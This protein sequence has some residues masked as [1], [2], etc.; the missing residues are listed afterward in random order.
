[1]FEQNRNALSK[2]AS[3]A[4]DIYG[5]ASDRL[6]G[7]KEVGASMLSGAVAQPVAGLGGLA[8]LAS[9]RNPTKTMNSLHALLTYQ[10]QTEF[11]KEYA[12]GL[13]RLMAPV[14]EISED[15]RGKLGDGAYRLTGSPAAAALAYST[16]EALAAYLGV[17]K[18]MT[19]K[20]A[21]A[22]LNT[23]AYAGQR[24]A[25]GFRSV[26]EF[27][28]GSVVSH[29]DDANNVMYKETTYPTGKRVVQAFKPHEK[30]GYSIPVSATE[31]TFSS[32]DDA[33]AGLG[34]AVRGDKIKAAHAAKY[35][36]IPERFSG[37]SRAIAKQ[38][39][40]SGYD[41]DFGTSGRST[42]AYATING[43][44]G[45]IKVRMSDHD[46]PVMTSANSRHEMTDIDY[47][48]GG[49]RD[50]LFKAIARKLE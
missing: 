11:G 9:G 3:A 15:A 27:G 4:A 29:F 25:T 46:L 8:A 30:F 31:K 7:M 49:D 23:G 14:A 17:R 10:P 1:M 39:I 44:N 13:A 48:I 26:D 50:Q 19:P 32:L 47:R 37:E 18:V 20:T 34:N 40:D 33:V 38:L 42:S 35:G 21:A 16:P 24:G 28:N 5:G 6:Y 2:L 41:V 36:S 12:N 45:S 22:P 43:K